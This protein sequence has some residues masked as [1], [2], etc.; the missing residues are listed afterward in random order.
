V[1]HHAAPLI[2]PSNKTLVQLAAFGNIKTSIIMLKQIA[3]E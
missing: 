1:T 2:A 3:E